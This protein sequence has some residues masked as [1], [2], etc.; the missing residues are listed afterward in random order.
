MYHAQSFEL[1]YPQA[2]ADSSPNHL[3]FARLACLTKEECVQMLQQSMS[4]HI[5]E[6]NEAAARAFL[7][8]SLR[9]AADTQFEGAC[10][11]AANAQLAAELNGPARAC[12]LYR[13]TEQRVLLVLSDY[14]RP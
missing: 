4:G 2:D 12:V 3:H 7:M 11:L 8:T 14:Y 13:M 5:S 6:R 9:R 1:F 10:S